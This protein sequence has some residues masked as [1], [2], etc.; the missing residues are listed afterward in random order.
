MAGTGRI[1]RLENAFGGFDDDGRERRE[2]EC[3]ALARLTS[4]ELETMEEYSR[5]PGSH[6]PEM[7]R[8]VARIQEK[9]LDETLPP[10]NIEA[11]F[12]SQFPSQNLTGDPQ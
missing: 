10:V 4:A 9:M 8:E 1:D 11:E 6:S 7:V 3:A 5:N 2:R 12:L